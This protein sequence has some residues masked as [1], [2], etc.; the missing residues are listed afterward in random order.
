MEGIQPNFIIVD[1]LTSSSTHEFLAATILGEN[2]IQIIFK[3]HF[4]IKNES[5]IAEIFKVII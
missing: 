5:Y 3:S 2:L 1:Q 4:I